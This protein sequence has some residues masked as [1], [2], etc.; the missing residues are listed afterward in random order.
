M[1]ISTKTRTLNIFRKIF[2]LPA[3]ERWL[4]ER[5]A[6]RSHKSFFSKLVPNI[7]QYSAPAIR[8]VD[9]NGLKLRVD[10]SDYLG[11]WYYFGFRD[12]SFESL[13][14]LTEKKSV[15]LDIGTNLGFTL[16]NFAQRA[17][18]GLVFGFE[19]D[20]VN[21]ANCKFNVEQNSF[22]NIRLMNFGLGN[23]EIMLPMEVRVAINR[24]GNRINISADNTVD[25]QIRRL[26]N[27]VRELGLTKIDIIK[28]D[29]E[30]FELN[31]LRGAAKTLAEMK[32]I[33]FIELDD[34]NLRDQGDSA[35]ELIQF[36][37]TLGYQEIIE[38]VSKKRLSIHN[39][40]TNCHY[41]ILA[42]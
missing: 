1:K 24:G 26:D 42:R 7:Y 17:N 34:G 4:V 30:G 18:E 25:V 11:H 39:D 14:V 29:V 9:R 40:F 13:F 16:L 15:V 10:I 2:Q 5:T 27:V 37:E 33:L 6:G 41:D 12:D 8:L 20:P 22:P 31:V 28:I 35:R 36:L 21:Y 19:P 3:L 32:P 38:I 23:E